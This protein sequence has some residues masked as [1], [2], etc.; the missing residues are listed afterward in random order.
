[1]IIGRCTQ[2]LQGYKTPYNTETTRRREKEKEIVLIIQP[3]RYVT[4]CKGVGSC[5]N[6]VKRWGEGDYPEQPSRR[7]E[8]KFRM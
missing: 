7:E 2:K 6:V 1:M 3:I 4:R 8:W 5:R